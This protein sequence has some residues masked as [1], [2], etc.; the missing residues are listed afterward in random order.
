VTLPAVGKNQ[1]GVVAATLDAVIEEQA[2]AERA[3]LPWYVG[4]APE[5]VAQ[6]GPVAG[7]G[8]LP[9][10]PAT[11]ADT[12]TMA[13][14]VTA[15]PRSRKRAVGLPGSCSI[16]PCISFTRAFWGLST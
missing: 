7:A 12:S 9:V 2:S 15:I 16:S 14:A 13:A 4:H 11:E 10:H 3:G 8:E 6:P 5:L 1:R